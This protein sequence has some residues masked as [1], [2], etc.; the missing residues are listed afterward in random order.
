MNIIYGL[1]DPRK[2]DHIRYVGFTSKGL[3]VRLRQ[4]IISTTDTRHTYLL[5]WLRSLLAVG[6]TPE[7]KLLERVGD[8]D[9][10]FCER[11]WVKRLWAQGHIL[12][13][14]TAGGEGL[15]NPSAEVR[16]KI[17]AKSRAIS[18]ESR[19]R[20]RL[21]LIGRRHTPETR[22]Q[23]SESQIRRRQLERAQQEAR[24]LL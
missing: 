3:S 23:M 11:V 20:I 13:N 21:Q 24:A 8:C 4:H 16:A 12:V 15:I 10:Q 14:G 6:I 17:A 22:R 1:V 19:E 9:W 2:R 18:K 5:H 7:I